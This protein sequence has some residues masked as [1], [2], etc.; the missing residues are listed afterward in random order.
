MH[1]PKIF[2]YFAG[3]SILLTAIACAQDDIIDFESDQW[4]LRDANVSEYMG[5]KC[6]SGFAYLKDIEFENG[7]I[8]VDVAVDGSRS[9]PG[10]VFRMQSERDYERFYLR[11]HRMGLYPDALQYT[12]VI[13]GI[14]GWQLY[15]GEGYTAMA[16]VPTDQ[17]VH[18]R[19]EIMG[20]QARLFVD[21]VEQ[22]ALVI[23][24]LQH[25]I[26][27]GTIG[28]HGPNN[29]TAYFSNF[30]YEK[31]DDL[32]FAPAPEI[33]TPLGIA[34]D[35]EISQTFRASEIN[36]EKSYDAQELPD[37]EWRR[38]Q[39]EPTGLIDLARYVG[40]SGPETDCIW[41]K[42]KVFSDKEETREYKF[43]YSDAICVFLN[44]EA[45]FTG[46]SAYRERDPSFLGIVGLFDA[47][48]LPLK[49]GENEL[50][51]LIAES[52]GGWG[53][54][55]Q[56]G[57][58][59]Y[60][61]ESMTKLWE[62]PR[63]L[64]MPESVVYDEKRDLLYVSNYF[65]GGNEFISKISLDGQIIEREWISGLNRPTGLCLSGDRL[66]V[67]DRTGLV[68]IDMESQQIAGKYPIPG[69]GFA[70]DITADESGQLYISD[71]RRNV[72]HKFFEGAFEVWLEGEE[73]RDPNGLCMDDN[74][75]VFGNS[76]D[77]CVKAAAIDN[78]SI[79]TI[80]EVGNGA[81]MD[82]VRP[83]GNEGYI[84]SDFNGR[85]FHVSSNGTKTELLNTT[86]PV[87]YC[88]DL[89]YIPKKGI[90]IIPSLYENNLAA[91]KYESIN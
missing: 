41:A 58:Y 29:K 25:G 80:I 44:G 48:Y 61:H 13:N 69:A 56:D 22:P 72:I 8:E 67:V 84:I 79:S 50:T 66:Y 23:H 34:K 20:S 36:L 52:F 31:R 40:R 77:G 43:G 63:Q 12:P 46:S 74:R 32:E 4:I 15:N 76:G 21:N 30:R 9:Y 91:Y 85:V 33:V 39:C 38:I 73:I 82:G 3:I 47:V 65:D 27:S 17:W 51:F 62:L 68:E 89:E 18:L 59:T 24:H 26:S 28:L 1:F 55:C 5:R 45:L 53:F 60:R 71:S 88:A 6:L 37:L 35:W 7:V 86:V 57:D 16:D 81:I 75:L 64:R 19:M 70:N 2:F 14:A 54:I 90:V 42:T 83:D 49:Q 11:P 10:L 78:K 87:K